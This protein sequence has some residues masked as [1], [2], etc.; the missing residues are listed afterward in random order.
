MSEASADRVAKAD[1]DFT[2]AR[3][4]LRQRARPLL[5]GVCRLGMMPDK[6]TVA[7]KSPVAR[8]PVDA[9]DTALR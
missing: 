3:L 5:G 4:L 9:P 2:A 6:V 1:A 8:W 7:D